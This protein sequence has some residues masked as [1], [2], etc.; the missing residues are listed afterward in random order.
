MD[1]ESNKTGVNSLIFFD[2]QISESPYDEEGDTSNVEGSR[3]VTSDDY[4]NTIE[5]EVTTIST[6]IEENFTFEGHGQNDSNGEDPSN[7]WEASPIMRRTGRQRNLPS[8]LNIF[9]LAVVLNMKEEME[10]E[11]TQTST[12]AKLPMLKQGDYEIWRLRI[13]QYFQVQDYALWDVKCTNEVPTNFEVSTA[14]PQ[15]STANL[16]DATVY[17]FLANQPNGSQ[18]VH[19]DLEQIHEDDLKEMDLKWQLT[20]LS[21]RAKRFF[22]KT[23]GAFCKRIQSAKEPGEQNQES[24]KPQEGHRMWK[25]QLLKQWWQLMELVLIGATWLM[26]KL[27]QTWTSCLFETQRDI[28]IKDSEIVVLKSKLEKINKENDN[29]DIKIKKSEN[30]YQSLDKLIESKINDKSKRG[31]GYVSYNAIP[32]PHIRRFSP[33]RIDLSHTGLPEFAEPNVKSYR[34]KP[35]EVKSKGEDEVEFPPKIERKAVKP[36]V[37]KVEVSKPKQNEKPARRPVKYVEMYRTQ[38][39]KG[40]QRNW[41]NLKSHQLGSNLS[42]TIKLVMPVEVL[43]I[44][45]LCANTIRGKGWP[46]NPKRSFQKRTTYN[47][48]NLFQKVNTAKGKVNTARLNPAVLNVVRANKG[49]ALEDQGYFDS[50]CSR[51][52]T[53]NISYLTDFKE[54][55]GGYVAFGGGAKGATKVETS[56]IIKSFITKIE[57]LVDK[58]VKIIRCDN[59]TEFK[60]NVMNEFYKAKGIKREYSVA[61]TPQQNGVAGRRNRTLIETTRTMWWIRWLF[62]ID[63]ITKSMNY[64]PVIA[65]TNSNDFEGKGTSFDADSHGNNKDKDGPCQESKIDNQE[66]PNAENSTKYVNTDGPSINTPSSNINIASLTVNIVRQ[67]DDFFG[68]DNEIRI[69]DGVEV[70]LCNISTTYPVPTTPNTRIH[71]D[72]SLDNVIGDMQSGVQ[73]RRMII[74]TDEQGFISAIYKK[75]THED[76]HTC[77][78]DCFLSQ[79][80]PKRITNVLKDPAWVEAMQEE[81]LQFHLQK[82]D[83][84]SA[85]LYD[86]IKEEV[87]VCQPRGF[88]D[89]DYPDNVYKVEKAL[90]GLHQALRAWYETLAKYLLDNG[91][92]KGKIDQTLFIKRQK[93]DILLIQV[94]VDDIIF[95]STKKELCTEFEVLMYDKFQMSSMGELTFF[96]RV[97]NVKPAITPMDK[98]KA[99]LKDSD[100]NDV[101]VHLY[102]L[103]FAGEAQ[104]IWLTL[105]LDKKMIKYELSNGLTLGNGEIELNAT[106]DGQDKTITEASVRRHLKLTYADGISTLPT[107]KIFEQLALMGHPALSQKVFSNIKRESRGFYGVEKTLFLTMLVHEQL[108]QGE[109][110]TSPVGTQHTPIVIETSPKLQNISKTYRKTRTRTRRMDIRI[111]QSNVSSSVV[112]EAITKEMHDGLGR[113]T[114][115]AFSLEARLERL[116]DLPNEPPLREGNTSES[117]EGSMQLLELM[118]ICTKLSDKVTTLENEIKSTKVVYNKAIITLTKRVNKLKKKLKHKRRRVV[119]DSSEDEEASL[120]H[121]DSP[122]Q[123]RII[124]EIDK[125]ENVNMVKSSKHKEEHETADHRMESDDTEVMDDDEETLAETLE[126]QAQL[127]M[128][129]E[130]AQQVQ[131]QWTQAD[132]DLAQRML[133]EE[134]ESLSIEESKI[135]FDNTMESIRNFVPMESE[136][137]IANFKAGERSSKEGESLK[138]PTEEELEQEQQKKQQVEEEID[139][140]K[141]VVAKQIVKEISK[142]AG[143][144]LKRKTSKAKE[145][146]DKRQKKQDD[147]EKLTLMDYVEV[148]SDS[149]EVISV[150]P[151][152]VKSPIVNWKSYCKGDVGYEIHR[153][154]GS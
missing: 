21:I 68:A 6:Q 93:E 111:P 36:S 83:V 131:A 46:V 118:A 55:D 65:G 5:D 91:F 66:R 148:I 142:K 29:L 124:K 115:T 30:A 41:N 42:C 31:L 153:A 63:T 15:V 128:D 135:L 2:V 71:K 134:R 13:E 78:F 64:V 81:L 141:N 138:R 106:V 20:L 38:R 58:K 130:Y 86:R 152:A 102:R 151:L 34:V 50:G 59:E 12:T 48:K 80:E 28:L 27:P 19:E 76:L 122:K 57:N 117:G 150:I 144:R 145:D 54:F 74:T 107:T 14:S 72:H 10:L 96:L 73:T 39:P 16:S 25:T 136:G 1:K 69:L 123:G 103:T 97:A 113:A 18:L 149:E 45:R 56:K 119:V 89:L 70:D 77:L 37:D 127:L 126:E 146:K 32:P 52:M 82:M 105:I 137:Q 88:K 49:K 101:D 147:P 61:R 33:S 47:N 67:S 7:V 110:P 53:R 129:E 17:A 35:I 112:D 94:Y 87:Y 100:G 8:K 90:Y 92:H 79:E 139:Q 133:E 40:N 84:K 132:E 121:E 109:G 99:L 24:R 60:N 22:Q 114:T 98:E 62:D 120:A 116:S 11:S 108:S 4:V 23:D 143:G 140:Q 44:C 85:F 125:D 75:N 51:H 9:L 43:I 95:G 154:D 26:M 104:Q 3:N